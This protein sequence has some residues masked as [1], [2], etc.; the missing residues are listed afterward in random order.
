M[1]VI[2]IVTCNSIQQ[3]T[4]DKCYSRTSTVASGQAIDRTH[5][6]PLYFRI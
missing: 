4:D 1:Y 3:T 5:L 6:R 2:F